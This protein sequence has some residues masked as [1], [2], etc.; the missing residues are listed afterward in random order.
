MP[1][2]T[3]LTGS[4]FFKLTVIKE[5]DRGE[6]RDRQWECLCDCGNTCIVQGNNLK[7]GHTKSCGCHNR[8]VASDRLKTHGKSKTRL[9]KIWYGMKNRCFNPMNSLYA[10]YGGRGITVCDEWR[11]SFE[12]FY[13]W[14]MTNGYTEGLTI[15]R[16]DVNRNYEPSNCRW[17]TIK[18]QQN[19]RRNNRLLEYN[20]ETHTIAQWAELK[21]LRKAVLYKRLYD[22]WSVERAITTPTSNQ[23]KAAQ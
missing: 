7:S 20:G 14:A 6:K 1:K 8:K 13:N 9:H 22:G 4:R 10:R 3:D 15:D 21:G 11:N 19:N 2:K 5:V 12:A 18:E 17:A 16:K 23:R